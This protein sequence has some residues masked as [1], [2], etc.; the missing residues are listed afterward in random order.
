MKSIYILLTKPDTIVSKVIGLITRD[1]YTHVSISF[2]KELCPLYSFSRKFVWLPLPAGLRTEQLSAPFFSNEQ[3]PCALYELQV[4]NEVYDLA[5]RVVEGMMGQAPRYR[6]SV[7]G[8][9]TCR[10]QIP[11]H[12][13]YC[14]FC[15]W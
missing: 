4:S 2:E 13:R 1:Q 3:V 7:I 11:F 12:R 5:R 10:L 15:C 9:F 8:L 14:Y 6:F